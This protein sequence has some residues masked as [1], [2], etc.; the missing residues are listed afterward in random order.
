MKVGF[1]NTIFINSVTYSLLKIS[2]HIKKLKTCTPLENRIGRAC[3]TVRGV[4]SHINSSPCQLFFMAE[5]S[6]LWGGWKV[7]SAGKE[8]RKRTPILHT[9]LINY[10]KHSEF[11]VYI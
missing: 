11:Y 6:T 3:F 1:L 7:R 10:F 9:T 2:K 5:S 4:I 8:R